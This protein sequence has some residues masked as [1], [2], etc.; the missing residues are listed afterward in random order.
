M[1]ILEVMH[2]PELFGPWFEDRASW[3]PWEAFLAAAFA[4][5]FEDASTLALFQAHTGRALPPQEQCREAWVIVGRR[6]GK[7]RV[8][9]L[10]AIYLACFRDYSKVLAPG[11]VGR[12]ALIA[13]D[14][15]QA[16]LVM[17]YIAGFVE[18]IPMLRELVVN[19]TRTTIEFSNRIAIEVHTASFRSVRGYSL[20]GVVCDEIAFWRTDDTSA[21]P[22][23]EILNGLRP[24][25]ATIPGAM[26]V[27][28]SS[29][30]AQRGALYDAYRKHFAKD[31]D[32]I[33]VWKAATR[34]M[35]PAIDQSVIEDAYEQDEAAAS[36]EYGA[37]FRRDIEAFVSRE[38]VDACVVP[39]RFEIPPVKGIRYRAFVDPSGGSQDSMTLAIA[40]VEHGRTILDCVRECKAPFKPTEVVA[41]LAIVLHAYG[42]ERVIG[43]HYAG[44]WPRQCFREHGI[45]YETAPKTKSQYYVE[46]LAIVNSGKL[47]L[48]DTPRLIGQLCGLERRTARGGR[49]SV[50]HGPGGHDDLINAVAGVAVTL[51]KR[52]S[53]ILYVGDDPATGA[54]KPVSNG[55]L[56]MGQITQGVLAP[57]FGGDDAEYQS[58]CGRCVY[59]ESAKQKCGLRLFGVQAK[60]RSCEL[61]DGK[62]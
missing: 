6:G 45:S 15:N 39:G 62:A 38:A 50:D 40:H 42:C 19:R 18:Q 51:A 33:L 10:I 12:L 25:M 11:E 29:P 57:Y 60:D 31:G 49:D 13:A 21:N 35:H 20:I 5:P 22:D 36:A 1:T 14:R 17:G 8:A 34:S 58:T 56:Y 32:R 53:Q 47:E 44:E 37:E 48:L 54:S 27:A 2:D 26:I 52:S 24:G 9:A 28:I 59:F 41:E 7:S 55:R 16:G 3:R 4:L 43:D 30:Y 23:T 46:L 61:Y